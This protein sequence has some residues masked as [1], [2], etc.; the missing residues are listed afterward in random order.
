M[1]VA[2]LNTKGGVGKSTTAV[3]LATGLAA[4][5]RTLLVDADLQQTVLRWSE[6][7]GDGFPPT[8]G[9]PVRDLHRRLAEVAAGYDHVVIDTPPG[10]PGISASAARAADVVV[11]PTSPTL[12]DIDRLRPTLELLTDVEDTHPVA[13]R[14][15]LTRVRA[16]TIAASGA[17]DYLDRHQLPLLRQPITLREA[18]GSSFGLVVGDLGEY[19][20]VL[21][22]LAAMEVAR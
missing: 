5:G 19:A 7:A 22:E 8:V 11:I 12:V 16:R 1:R 21:E 17:R 18:Y 9:L 14:V 10:N 15:L 6:L 13:L 4:R 3:Y 2:L 20:A